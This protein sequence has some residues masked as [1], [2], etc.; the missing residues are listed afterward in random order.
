MLDRLSALKDQ[1]PAHR[2]A[3]YVDP[4]V[5]QDYEDSVHLGHSASFHGFDSVNDEE[6]H[7]FDSTH[8]SD[9]Y[10]DPE[11]PMFPSH[12]PDLDSLATNA[13]D[14][15]DH[16]PTHCPNCQLDRPCELHSRKRLHGSDTHDPS[17]RHKGRLGRRRLH[18]PLE[19]GDHDLGR[20]G[21]IRTH[22]DSDEDV[23][24][25]IK[26]N[27]RPQSYQKNPNRIS[28]NDRHGLRRQRQAV[29]DSSEEDAKQF[30]YNQ[31][32]KRSTEDNNPTQHITKRRCEERDGPY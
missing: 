17:K 27:L 25:H 2:P 13:D 12:D 18:A 20:R 23:G 14:E 26:L 22:S 21:K 10:Y 9:S 28:N 32:Q 7:G 19:R 8:D 5:P 3:E 30:R 16:V 11:R 29:T 24:K 4:A 15:S 6:F 1:P 31:G